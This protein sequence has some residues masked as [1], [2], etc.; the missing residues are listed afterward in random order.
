MS[1]LVVLTSDVYMNAFNLGINPEVKG[2]ALSAEAFNE[3]IPYIGRI[4][5][6]IATVFFALSTILGWAYYGEVCADYLFKKNSKTAV[7]TYRLIYVAFVFIGA[8]ASIDI[9][10]L[11][12]DCF[13]ALMAV[14]NLIALICLSKT[15][16]K[17]TKSHLKKK[18][19][20]PEIK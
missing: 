18:N 7:M 11:V 19:Q 9:V 14:P 5:I 13:N 12:A 6:T 10:W 2:A 17:I 8:V 1:A 4:G 15:V 16:V 20:I 3:A